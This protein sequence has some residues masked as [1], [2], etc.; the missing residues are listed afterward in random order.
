MLYEF[1]L[2]ISKS[3]KSHNVAL[4]YIFFQEKRQNQVY[5]VMLH[6]QSKNP[7]MTLNLN[8]TLVFHFICSFLCIN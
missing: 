3:E 1:Y 7:N 2:R 5:L 6:G 8:L 4:Q